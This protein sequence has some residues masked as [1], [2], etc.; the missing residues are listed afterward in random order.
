MTNTART[1]KQNRL[2]DWVARLSSEEMPAFA[3]TAQSLAHVS[4]DKDSSANDL[5]NII[6][7]DSTMTARILRIANSVHYNPGGT[8]IETVSYATVV[9]GFEQV[10]NL[11]LTISMIDTVLAT[12][13]QD[14]I[15]KEMICAYHAA[16]QAQRLVP[17]SETTDPEAVYIG[18]LLHRLG[19]L[20]FWCFPFGKGDELLAA[21]QQHEVPEKAEQKVL[22]FRLDQLTTALVS[23]W[24][25]S[26]MLAHILKSNVVKKADQNAIAIGT[27]IADNIHQGWETDNVK[28]IIAAAAKHLNVSSPEARDYI[29]DSA[30]IASEGLESFNFSHTQSL[31]PPV[32]ND[33]LPIEVSNKESAELE[34]RMLRQLT[35]MLG[36]SLDINRILMA[37]LEAIYRVLEMD[38]VVFATINPRNKRLQAKL[39]IGKRKDSFIDE[40]VNSSSA[41]AQMNP[42]L[43]QWFSDGDAVWMNDVALRQPANRGID[44]LITELA[45]KEFFVSPIALSSNTVKPITEMPSTIKRP[46]GIIYADRFSQQKQLTTEN[47][48]SFAH[49]ADHAALAFKFLSRR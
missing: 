36:E 26:P 47:L 13:L 18:A 19:P 37:V 10:R 28:S 40:A 15:Q 12:E 8:P 11:A 34:L 17:T 41:V 25:I 48:R 39:M 1:T 16:V 45:A 31:L 27:G 5:S 29:Y 14:Q 30:R 49:L 6:L 42:A 7:H 23:E 22:G 35:H 4:R 20:M 44:P 33:K 2:S 21:Y 43:G 3:H 32:T 46:I 9:L 24:K 38:Q